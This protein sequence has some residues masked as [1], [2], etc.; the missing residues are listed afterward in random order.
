M[1]QSSIY[2]FFLFC[3]MLF[4]FPPKLSKVY[5]IL[6]E[7][8]VV[9]NSKGSRMRMI[10]TV[11][12]TWPWRTNGR[13]RG[14]KPKGVGLHMGDKGIK[15]NPILT[16]KFTTPGTTK[17]VSGRSSLSSG[18]HQP[19]NMRTVFV[20]SVRAKPDTDKKSNTTVVLR[21]WLDKWSAAAPNT[22]WFR[23]KYRL[24]CSG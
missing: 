22:E 20:V 5:R 18:Y 17:R 12:L 24:A 8:I 11:E 23:G 14:L 4:T 21:F 7:V 13:K 1:E 3:T 9:D 2:I 16:V 10:E 6:Q 19:R 15:Y